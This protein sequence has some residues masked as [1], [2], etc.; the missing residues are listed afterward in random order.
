MALGRFAALAALGGSVVLAG[1]GA[2]ALTGVGSDSTDAMDIEAGGTTVVEKTWSPSIADPIGNNGVAPVA[3]AAIVD[4]TLLSPFPTPVPSAPPVL[5]AMSQGESVE[6]S[7]SE[8]TGSVPSPAA[9]VEAKPA[10]VV[11]RLDREG[12]LTVAEIARIKAS[13]NLTPDQER[14][15]IP[16]EVELREI[17]RQLA[18]RKISTRRSTVALGADEAQRL[19]WAAGPFLMSL[20][21]DQKQQV[22]QL[23]RAMGLD[24]VAALI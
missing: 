1:W 7:Q 23:A 10:I 24:R 16:V 20:R 8:T 2:F 21:E 6:R 12:N 13:L 18:A 3:P 19:Y 14:H 17:V 5:A 4:A 11:P 9:R 22:R 15:W